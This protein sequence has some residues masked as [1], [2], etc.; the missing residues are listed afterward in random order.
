M[1]STS[2]IKRRRRATF[3]TAVLA[4]LAAGIAGTGA[5]HAQQD[6]PLP[7]TAR[8]PVA[9]TTLFP[10]G[11]HMPPEN[12]I[13]KKYDGSAQAISAGERLFNWYNCSGC[14]FH[15]AGGM[16]PPLMDNVWIY[17]GRIDQIFDTIARGR[18]NGMPSWQSKIPANEI[19]E[20]AAY[21]RSLSAP[22]PTEGGPGEVQPAPA[23]PPNTAPAPTTPVTI[24]PGG[25][26]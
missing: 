12:P 6:K 11:G 24:P 8:E 21:V 5:L 17:G 18:P 19:W 4:F 14:H 2:R 20:I 3:A 22:K 9:E 16:G 10:G 13:G 15:G 26:Q 23:P 25:K 7:D 1:S